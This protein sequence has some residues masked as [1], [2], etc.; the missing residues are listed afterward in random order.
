M[1]VVYML[2]SFMAA[3][4]LGLVFAMSRHVKRGLSAAA[5]E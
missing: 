2:C 5:G 4:P 3:M 1:L